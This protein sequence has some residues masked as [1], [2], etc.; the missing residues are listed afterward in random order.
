MVSVAFPFVTLI[1]S[2]GC[3][4]S[5]L[6]RDMLQHVWQEMEY[7]LDIFR[8]TNGPHMES[9]NVSYELFDL[10]FNFKTLISRMSNIFQKSELKF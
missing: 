10:L 3:V 7:Q 6:L 5:S 1:C 4:H 8:A 9:T 2:A